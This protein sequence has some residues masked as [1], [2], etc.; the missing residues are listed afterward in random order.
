[1]R[2]TIALH[3]QNMFQNCMVYRSILIL[4]HLCSIVR[5]NFPLHHSHNGNYLARPHSNWW[6]LVVDHLP[7][8]R[9]FLLLP[10][11]FLTSRNVHFRDLQ[12]RSEI[13]KIIFK[14]D[15]HFII[16]KSRMCFSSLSFSSCDEILARCIPWNRQYCAALNQFAYG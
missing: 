3:R 5:D 16:P 1:M 14:I 6:M 10:N 2:Q 4:F 8:R 11:P 13:N 15:S 9:N 12:K 7:S